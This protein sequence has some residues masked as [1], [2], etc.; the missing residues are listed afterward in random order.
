MTDLIAFT[1]VGI[2]TGSVYAVAATGLVL[3]Y[4][5]SNI[6]NIAHGAVGMVMAFLYWELSANR[7]VPTL[8]AL[9][10]VVFVAAPLFGAVVERVLIRR[11]QG[12]SVTVSLVST[13]GLMLLLL[14]GAQTIWPPTARNI[15]GFFS[16]GGMQLGTFFI[17]WHQVVTIVVAGAVAGLLY[18]LLLRTRTG[19]AMRAVVDDRTLLALM[20]GSPER[21]SM[22]SWALG[23][24]LAAVAGI[25]LAPVLQLDHLVLTFLVINAYA[26][27][28]VGRLKSL[29]LT[30]V[31]AI[32][33]GLLESYAV[34]YLPLT[35]ALE[36][37]RR[38]L[39]TLFLFAA[40][41]AV[42]EVRLR[43]GRVVGA[44]LP[45]IPSWRQ[46]ALAGIALISATW[47][48]TGILSGS[49]TARLGQGLA[50]GLIMLSLVVLTGFGGQVSLCQLTFA[51]MG[52]FVASQVGANLFGLV[53]AAL[54]AAV[55]GAIVALPALRVAGLYLALATMAF[56]AFMD[57]MFFENPNVFGYGGSTTVGRLNVFGLHFASERSYVVLLAIAFALMS[58]LVVAVRRSKLGRLLAAMRDS[59]AA[60]AMLGLNLTRLKLVVFMIS[61]GMAGVAGA[62]FAGLRGAAGPIDFAMLQ[63]LPLL[64]LAVIGGI[65]SASGALLGGMI[66][67]LLPMLQ[68]RFA[69]LAG[70]VFLLIGLAAVVLGRNPN[71][72]AFVVTE[73]MGRIRGGTDVP[74]L[75]DDVAAAGPPAAAAQVGDAETMEFEGVVDGTVPR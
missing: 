44:T 58:V 1:I 60:C 24:S 69:A 70:L 56:A 52:A 23:S 33:L 11:L 51:G 64:L 43:V 6:F 35:G 29:P 18:L 37:M 59:P 15:S 28:V 12:A 45:R 10:L 46:T 32:A 3:T 61:A 30:F 8:L 38:V 22:L 50:F 39:P 19:I 68:D 47:L 74:V 41:L 34:G 54:F 36:N 2:V 27:A 53:G 49:D 9:V 72:L 55:A 16:P 66:Y 5:T 31:G 14:G 57:K 48:L 21:T 71:G 67:A 4:T 42:P 25:L 73:W 63:S 20:G 17:T 65:T 62:L 75:G 40:L 13:L 26:A 7:G